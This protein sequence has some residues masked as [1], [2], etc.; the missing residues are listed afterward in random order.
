MICRVTLSKIRPIKFGEVRKIVYGA[1]HQKGQKY[2]ID[3]KKA[4]DSIGSKQTKYNWF[5]TDCV[6]YSKYSKTDA[7]LNREYCWISDEDLTSLI[8]TE[9]FQWIWAVLCGFDKTISLSE[10]LKYGRPYADGY[11]GFWKL[12]LTMQH[13]L[14]EIEIVLWDSSFVLIF[15]KNKDIV[16]NF[17]RIFPKSE[18][19]EDYIRKFE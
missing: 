16:D 3:L 12:P 7:M 11:E 5:I 17:R 14:A 9:N 2:H 13:P 4:L 18:N 6:C 1:I 15:S 19:L 10:I 8:C